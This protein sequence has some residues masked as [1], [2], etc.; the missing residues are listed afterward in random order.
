VITRLGYALLALLARM[1]STGYELSARVRRPLGYF[2]AAR[3]GQIYPELTRLEE[4][5]LVRFELSPGPGPHDKKVYS[6]TEAGLRALGLWVTMPPA[7]RAERDDLLLKAYACWTAD[8]TAARGLF[9]GQI[10]RHEE[11]LARYLQDWEKVESRH[12]GGAPPASHP[13]FGSY[14][15]LR[16]GIDYERHRIAW[17]RWMAGQLTEPGARDQPAGPLRMTPRNLM[18]MAKTHASLAALAPVTA[19]VRVVVAVVRP[20]GGAI[21]SD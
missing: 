13:D 14:A 5:G 4:A 10:S 3:H 12:G 15:T 9:A 19:V 8:S 16:Y 21:V 18:S 17:L 7:D 20:A 6:L 1:P 11:V 2:W